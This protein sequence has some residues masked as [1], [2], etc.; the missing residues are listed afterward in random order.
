[1]VNTAGTSSMAESKK[2]EIDAAAPVISVP[3]PILLRH[4]VWH[5]MAFAIRGH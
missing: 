5:V 3:I 4:V 2:G 1:M